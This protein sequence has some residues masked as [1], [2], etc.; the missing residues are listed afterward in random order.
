MKSLP[1]KV[2]DLAAALTKARG[3]AEAIPT[4]D[5]GG[6]CNFDCPELF[7]PRWRE[8]D[9]EAAAKVAGCTANK[10]RSFG[11][12]TCYWIGGWP[13]AQGTNQTIKAEAAAKSLK[14]DGY[15]CHVHY[16]MD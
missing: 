1:V 16:A 9:V 8:S 12:R 3:V 6:T 7:L 5:T 13:S 10:S 14:A 4:A 11:G 2:L 15:D